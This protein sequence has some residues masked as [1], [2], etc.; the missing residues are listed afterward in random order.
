MQRRK[1][2]VLNDRCIH[3]QKAETADPDQQDEADD[4]KDTPTPDNTNGNP[5]KIEDAR[6]EDA[7]HSE[8]DDEDWTPPP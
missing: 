8:T 4:I 6:E 1:I 3:E 5:P 7:P 2:R